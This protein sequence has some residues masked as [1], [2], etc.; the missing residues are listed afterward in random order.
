MRSINGDKLYRIKVKD[1]AHVNNHVKEDG[2]KA[3]IQFDEENNLQGPVDL[4]E[5]DENEYIK[6]VYTE[7]IPKERSVGQVII[8][9]AVI[10]AITDVLTVLA[11]RAIDVGVDALF[12]K[13]IPATKAKGSHIINKIKTSC[14]KNRNS[15]HRRVE[16]NEVINQNTN[17]NNDVEQQ[18]IYHSPKEVNQIINNMRLAALYIAAGIRELSDTV[19]VEVDENEKVSELENKYNELSS[20]QVMNAIDFMLE[21]KNRDK[22][23]QATLQLFEAFRNHE[24]IIDGKMVPISNYFANNR[25][26]TKHSDSL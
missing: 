5:V 17:Q 16:S 9:D 1:G 18:V 12:T 13:V 3:A 19:I 6:E 7:P 10:P 23:D 21:E 25:L 2:S 22:L 4:I 20:E 14:Q 8:E 24:F 26:K 11:E 15:K